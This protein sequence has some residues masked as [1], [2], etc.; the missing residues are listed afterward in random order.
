[1]VWKCRRQ[2]SR[3]L[4]LAPSVG[5]RGLVRAQHPLSSSPLSS[6]SPPS[7]ALL[8]AFPTPVAFLLVFPFLFPLSKALY[9]S[10]VSRERK[11]MQLFQLVI[12]I[13]TKVLAPDQLIGLSQPVNALLAQ[14]SFPSQSAIDGASWHR[15]TNSLWF[16][17]WPPA[18]KIHPSPGA[19]G[20][21]LL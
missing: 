14:L 4:R 3:S 2:I 5:T 13:L 20:A 11:K 19:G 9:R 6:G 17:S 10:Q 21:F 15:A 12:I 18:H 1:M 16:R 8:S 7:L